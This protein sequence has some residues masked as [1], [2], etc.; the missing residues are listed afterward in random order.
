[1]PQRLAD[2]LRAKID[3]DYTS[4]AQA[5]AE[6]GVQYDRLKRSL[7]KN[8]FR[9]SD[10]ELLWPEA[11]WEELQS[12]YEFGEW[13]AY[14]AK[15]EFVRD[16]QFVLF[17][18][19]RKSY[20]LLQE[21][22]NKLDITKLVDHLYEKISNDQ[23]MFLFCHP[24]KEPIEWEQQKVDYIPKLAHR[25]AEGGNIFYIMESDVLDDFLPDPQAQD[26]CDRRF[27][28]FLRDIEHSISSIDNRADGKL[29]TIALLRVARCRFCIPY[30]KPALFVERS[31]QLY[32]ALTTVDLPKTQDGE[33]DGG[34]VI[35][36]QRNTVANKMR[37]Y[38]W[39]MVC[40]LES[41]PDVSSGDFHA[42]SYPQIEKDDLVKLIKGFTA[43][44]EGMTHD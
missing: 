44:T 22:A 28:G 35:V 12:T 41:G 27:R 39:N 29:G 21:A 1:M 5:A 17:E 43:L 18:P 14:Q 20:D 30:Q 2:V 15:S 10:L 37:E 36:P 16:G 19:L 31:S 4:V 33:G 23:A 40:F 32:H 42:T 38:L 11:T 7:N 3:N 25:L 6:S 8:R 13:G 34:T 9:R 24:T 26:D